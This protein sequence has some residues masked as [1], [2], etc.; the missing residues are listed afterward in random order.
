[1]VESLGIDVVSCETLVGD[2]SVRLGREEIMSSVVESGKQPQPSGQRVGKSDAVRSSLHSHLRKTASFIKIMDLLVYGFAWLGGILALWFVACL[3]D[4][5]ILPL[6]SIVRW[7]FWFAGVAGT[8]AWAVR[9]VGPLL[10]GRINES[11]AAKRIEHLVPEFKNGLISWL[12]L[13]QLPDHGVPRGV[14]AALAYRAKRYIGN[15]DPSAT[16]DTTPLI[17]LIAVLLLLCTSL[18]VYAVVSPKSVGVTGKRIA[19]P[20]LSLSSPNRVAFL[21]ITPGSTQI[22]QGSELTIDVEISGLLRGEPVELRFSTTDGQLQ[23]QIRPLEAV[24]EGFR[25]QTT[26]STSDDGVQQPLRYWL[27]AGDAMEGPFEVTINPLPTVVVESVQLT[28]PSYTGLAPRSVDVRSDVEAVE[29]TTATI[30]ANAN[31]SMRRGILDINPV[32]DENSKL[33]SSDATVEMQVDGKSLSAD[34]M[35]RL[36]DQRSNPTSLQYQVRGFNDELES[37]L[38]PLVHSLAVLA[39]LPPEVTLVGPDSRMLRVLPNTSFSAEIRASDPDY[40]LASIKLGVRKNSKLVGEKQ[41]LKS[42]GAKGQQVKNQKLNLGG[43]NLQP[44]D[45]VQ[46]VAI[47]EDNRHSPETGKWDPN[48]VVSEPLLL[49]I[50]GP[51]EK[52]DIPPFSEDTEESPENTQSNNPPE[53]SQSPNQ[54]GSRGGASSND[55]DPSQE[56]G[57]SQDET[58]SEKT[59]SE[60]DEGSQ[61]PQGESES[62]D[63]GQGMGGGNE[64][65]TSTQTSNE[66]TGGNSASGQESSARS[67]SNQTTSSESNS[68]QRSGNSQSADGSGNSNQS[69]SSEQRTGTDSNPNSRN[70]NADGSDAGGDNLSDG[71]VMERVRDRIQQERT[72]DGSTGEKTGSDNNSQ[73]DSQEPTGSDSNS[74]EPASENSGN[75]PQEGSQQKGSNEEG[76]SSN[77]GTTDGA[78]DGNERNQQQPNSEPSNAERGGSESADNGN[79]S[80]SESGENGNQQ[81]QNSSSSDTQNSS[82]SSGSDSG[83]DGQQSSGSNAGD[84]QNNGN[85]S[86]GSSSSSSSDGNQ[87]QGNQGSQDG[88]SD[89]SSKGTEGSSSQDSSSNSQS[90]NGSSSQDSGSK[91]GSQSGSQNSE[92]GSSSS[93]DSNSE[94]GSESNSESGNQSSNSQNSEG[95]NGSSSG[96]GQKQ[97]GS[98]GQEGAGGQS[99]SAESRGEGDSN[100]EQPNDDGSPQ[101]RG[102]GES[103]SQSSSDQNSAASSGQDSPQGSAKGGN[104]PNTGRSTGGGTASPSGAAGSEVGEADSANANY[105]EQT[106]DMV[107]DYLDRQK[108]QPDPDLLKDLD[109][110]KQDLQDFLKRWQEAR[111]LGSNG[112]EEEKLRWQEKLNQL[113]LQPPGSQRIESQTIDDTFQKMLDSGTRA[114][115]PA[116]LR[117]E[118]EAF[119]KALQQSR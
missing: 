9:Y 68:N 29:G 54:E 38:R 102:G 47:A 78:A 81:N 20:W 96:E 31:Q 95:Q 105:A 8:G 100:A 80:Q 52:P 112:S 118:L 114:R 25:Y 3:I 19:F 88:S 111:D 11:Y 13:E 94:A 70:Q 59:R 7:F 74:G 51:S 76:A 35:M 40:G 64:E 28:Y 36:D 56:G 37:N 75:Q 2:Q 91:S 53:K 5:W 12:E 90:S 50:I 44:G 16:V 61:S 14:M 45:V 117:K 55:G 41:L 106:T 10:L 110:S 85:Q 27:E 119:R 79:S 4:H 69:R 34:W 49:E 116:A 87:S 107:L 23:N 1:M 71:E 101:Q 60:G 73:E 32:L 42:N 99:D 97:D 67:R 48:S 98:S 30:K 113:G 72:P 62:G 109:W 6:P 22:T 66:S 18:I 46:L 83:S 77:S 115:P 82:S 93:G 26:I 108:D 92:S 57:Q 63:Q 43:M 86:Q 17:K 24:T 15:Q 89:S 65:A 104:M 84:Q 39:D 21:K 103:S 58:S 33:V